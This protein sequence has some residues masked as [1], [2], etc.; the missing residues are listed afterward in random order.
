[1][2]TFVPLSSSHSINK[3]KLCFFAC[4]AVYTHHL[5]SDMLPRD[6][7]HL[8]VWIKTRCRLIKFALL[9]VYLSICRGW[10]LRRCRD[11]QNS[12]RSVTQLTLPIGQRLMND[13]FSLPAGIA[14]SPV[15]AEVKETQF[16]R[17]KSRGDNLR[18]FNQLRSE[19]CRQGKHNQEELVYWSL[20][21]NKTHT[22][23]DL[24]RVLIHRKWFNGQWLRRI[25]ESSEAVNVSEMH[26]MENGG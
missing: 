6:R 11:T 20:K 17:D 24:Q 19:C 16:R 18:W 12:P 8:G 2:Y 1:M 22:H 10:L 26:W 13:Y 3:A 21:K 15:A 4:S 25:I 23:E 7:A 5:F 14:H 9:R